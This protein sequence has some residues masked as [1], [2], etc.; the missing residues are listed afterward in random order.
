[1]DTRPSHSLITRVVVALCVVVMGLLATMA[2]GAGLVKI[3]P[4]LIFKGFFSALSAEPST[5]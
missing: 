1:M 3:S 5:S 2:V 4:V